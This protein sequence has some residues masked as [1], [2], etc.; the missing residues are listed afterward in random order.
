[1]TPCFEVHVTMWSENFGRVQKVADL[2]K[3]QGLH[4]NLTL[5]PSHIVFKMDNPDEM[6]RIGTN[7]EIEEAQ[8]ELDPFKHG[9]IC[10]TWIDA[11]YVRHAHARSAAPGGPCN[12]WARHSDGQLGRGIQYPFIKPKP[13]EWHSEWREEKLEP[14][15]E[16]FR[17]LFRH[18]AR[19]P[20]SSLAT[21]S[22]EFIPYPD[23]GGG[24]K[25]SLFDQNIACAD[26]LRGI[27]QAEL[28]SAER[29]EPLSTQD[30]AT[31]AVKN[32]L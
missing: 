28:L 14:W 9:N 26:W 6:M 29:Q 23:Y 3:A 22:T 5:D 13:G 2:V 10:Q 30:P 19:N 17:Q 27:W 18:H 24:A 20:E 11:G 16:V 8:L 25:Y 12:K 21:V 7:G 32:K 15:K 4:F 31:E 1:M